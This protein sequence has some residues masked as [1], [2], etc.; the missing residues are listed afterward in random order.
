MRSSRHFYHLE[1]LIT[2]YCCNVRPLLKYLSVVWLPHKSTLGAR[3]QTIQNRFL[4]LAGL[5]IGYAYRELPL[6]VLAEQ[7]SLP[8]LL[9]RR[10]IQG[11]MILDKLVNVAQLV[12]DGSELLERIN[13]HVLTATPGTSLVNSTSALTIPRTPL[14]SAPNGLKIPS[15]RRLFCSSHR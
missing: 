3:L 1:T 5:R 8:T 12:M 15:L 6:D 9:T 14:W 10:T 7:M 11:I 13:C 2:F 4:R